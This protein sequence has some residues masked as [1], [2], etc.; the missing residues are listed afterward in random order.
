MPFASDDLTLKQNVPTVA[1]DATQD[2]RFSQLVETVKDAFCIELRKFFAQPTVAAARFAEILHVE[3]YGIPQPNPVDAFETMVSI[4]REYPDVL[5]KLPLVSVTKSSGRQKRAGISGAFV[6]HVQ[7]PP[8]VRTANAEPY[9]LSLILN[10]AAPPRLVFTTMPDGQN[11][12]TSTMLFPTTPFFPTPSAVTAQQIANA[13]NAQALHATARAVTVGGSVYLEIMAGGPV[14]L[15]RSGGP[16]P[17]QPSSPF[18]SPVS[19]GRPYHV[20]ARQSQ[21][22]DRVEI[23]GGTTALL[24]AL[25]LTVGQQDDS[26][27]EARP[28]C[29]RYAT[30]GEFTIGI[31]VGARSDNERTEIT[32]LLH[33]FF[34]LWLDD[35]DYTF[36]GQHVFE[37]PTAG[38]TTE[39]YFQITVNDWQMAGEADIPLPDG[40]KEKKVYANR[41]NVPVVAFDYIDR[42]ISSTLI[43]PTAELAQRNF[44]PE[45]S[46]EL[47]AAS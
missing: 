30:G 6:G 34:N 21:T 14:R 25:G 37:E 27:N 46:E 47:P 28:P 45:S 16:V 43:P 18:F 32:D 38:G 41:F 15:T 10:P 23:L 13:I 3:K 5:Q 11:G 12:V 40:E 36:Y 35:R 26:T 33:Y 22:P 9:D 19:A 7:Y 24:T 29:N 20:S 17:T 31:D 8:R 4:I 2:F 42:I 39:R 1:T 44:I